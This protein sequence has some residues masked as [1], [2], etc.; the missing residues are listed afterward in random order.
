MVDSP[1]LGP[2]NPL[3]STGR[4]GQGNIGRDDTKYVDAGVVREGIAGESADGEYSSGR[5]GAGNIVP[6]PRIGPT[7]RRLSHD[8]IPEASL[9]GG[10]GKPP[11]VFHTGVSWPVIE[12]S[13]T[14]IDK[15]LARWWRKCRP[16]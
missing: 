14:H 11:A 5:G 15:L 7:G 12:P 8:K 1:K 6:S 10:T 16:C 9:M 3:V 4:G 2:K 13:H